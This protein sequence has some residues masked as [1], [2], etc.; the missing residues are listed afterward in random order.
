[1]RFG[2]KMLLKG[3]MAKPKMVIA[4][5]ESP[6]AGLPHPAISRPTIAQ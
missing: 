3:A 4:T 1:M 2:L 5:I 6:T